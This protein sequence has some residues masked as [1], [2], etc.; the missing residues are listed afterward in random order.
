ML[1]LSES[2]GGRERPGVWF[3]T[4]LSTRLPEHEHG[5]TELNL[6]VAGRVRYRALGETFEVSRGEVLVLAQGVRHELIEASDDVAMWVVESELEPAQGRLEQLAVL[7]PTSS[8]MQAAVTVTKKL[9]M[10]PSSERA[11]SLESELARLLEHFEPGSRPPLQPLHPAVTKARLI[12][13]QEVMDSLE[14]DVLARR[15]GISGSR[16]AHLFQAQLGLS[17]L[18]YKNF[19]RL[20][21]FIRERSGDKPT[22]L[23]AALR[24]GFGSYAQFHRIFHQVCGVAPGAHLAWLL[25]NDDVDTARTMRDVG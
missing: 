24:A 3:S 22:I 19:A 10:R 25:E 11:R 20:Q 16:L 18:Q 23:R 4:A 17:P 9:W 21:H 1:S 6:L 7:A 13:E 15:A 2:R 12:C 8:W 5:V 14:M